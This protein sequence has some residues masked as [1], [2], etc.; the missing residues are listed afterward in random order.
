MQYL[1]IKKGKKGR[2]RDENFKERIRAGEGSRFRIVGDAPSKWGH[3]YKTVQNFYGD[4]YYLCVDDGNTKIE[5]ETIQTPAAEK[6]Q[7]RDDLKKEKD[8]VP[9][10]NKKR[11][12]DPLVQAKETTP[13]YTD[14]KVTLPDWFVN[15]EN[16][17]V[18]VATLRAASKYFEQIA[19][20][21]DGGGNEAKIVRA[22]KNLS[23]EHFQKYLLDKKPDQ[24]AT[25]DLPSLKKALPG[26]GLQNE[27][28]IAMLNILEQLADDKVK[29]EIDAAYL[30]DFEG[31]WDSAAV[32]VP[33]A[34]LQNKKILVRSTGIFSKDLPLEVEV[35]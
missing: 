7:K 20:R 12:I 5:T 16:D 35:V 23:V 34:S 3:T 26:K 1:V 10:K 19:K 13:V 31:D 6:K 22:L 33:N 15:A 17:V 4:T 25:L 14:K 18:R 32:E 24:K 29:D 28:Y 11:E 30:E 8:V 9:K 2:L 27:D 21:T